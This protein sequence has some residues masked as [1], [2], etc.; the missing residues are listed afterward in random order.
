MTNS[1]LGEAEQVRR[2]WPMFIGHLNRVPKNQC[3]MHLLNWTFQK[4]TVHKILTV[5]LYKHAYKI[6]MV[7]LLQEEN[8]HSRLDLCQPMKSKIDNSNDILDKLT[9]SDEA[10]FHIS[11]KVNH[12]NC[13]IWGREK[14]LGSL[15]TWE[16]LPE[17]SCLMCHQEVLHYQSCLFWRVNSQWQILLG[18]AS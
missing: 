17:R 5:E 16:N 14:T 7:Q 10:T 8:Y 15:A 12:H 13:H 11:G 3:A 6:Q 18:N 4:T 9:F 2:L 1:D